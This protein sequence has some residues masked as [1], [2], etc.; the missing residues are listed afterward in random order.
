MRTSWITHGN[1]VT[2]SYDVKS[3]AITD[4]ILQAY[5]EIIQTYQ[6]PKWVVRLCLA[7]QLQVLVLYIFPAERLHSTPLVCYSWSYRCCS[8]T[9]LQG[10]TGGVSNTGEWNVIRGCF[11]SEEPHF[12]VAMS[13][14]VHICTHA[15]LI[16]VY[17]LSICWVFF[18]PNPESTVIQQSRLVVQQRDSI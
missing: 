6:S 16:S 4:Q 18:T 1:W 3:N 5:A 17:V 12:K 8:T 9:D 14:H 2:L 13:I 11:A 7:W 10:C 15:V